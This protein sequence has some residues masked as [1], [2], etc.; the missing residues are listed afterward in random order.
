MM[1]STKIL[2]PSERKIVKRIIKIRET[3]DRVSRSKR[4][5]AQYRYLRAILRGY[6]Y[7]DDHDLISALME[8]APATLMVPVR[9]GW[10]PLRVL[11]EATI[12]TEIDCKTLSRWTR[13][14]EYAAA[15][16]IAPDELTKFLRANNGIAGCADM[17]SMTQP[18]RRKEPVKSVSRK[19]ISASAL[20]GPAPKTEP[21]QP[22]LRRNSGVSPWRHGGDTDP[23][24]RRPPGGGLLKTSSDQRLTWLRG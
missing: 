7:L 1:T 10:H 8:I 13:A 22:H 11:L 15:R 23:K 12:W 19:T 17:M 24:T 9:A 21:R 14:L 16:K 3:A 2:L 18:K 4:R 5:F 6:R 20:P